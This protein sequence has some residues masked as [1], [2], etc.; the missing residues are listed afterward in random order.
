MA[1]WPK[2]SPC[3]SQLPPGWG[4]AEAGPTSEPQGPFSCRKVLISA[5]G[6]PQGTSDSHPMAKPHV[7]MYRQGVAP[8][9]QGMGLSEQLAGPQ[10]FCAPSP[11]LCVL[12]LKRIEEKPQMQ[13]EEEDPGL[14]QVTPAMSPPLRERGRQ[15]VQE[16]RP[17]LHKHP[18]EAGW[19]TPAHGRQRRSPKCAS[20]TSPCRDAQTE[21]RAQRW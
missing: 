6:L 18:R 1:C 12:K 14:R 20:F 21:P 17:E 4:G 10:Q 3:Q 13:P 5:L 2:G 8:V 7:Q 9:S 15:P 19:D 16:N 11:S